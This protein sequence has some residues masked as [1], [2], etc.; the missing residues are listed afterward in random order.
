VRT[1]RTHPRIGWVRGDQAMTVEQQREMVGLRERIN[2]LETEKLAA[3]S[4]LVEDLA[5]IAQGDE[6]VTIPLLISDKYDRNIERAL[7]AFTST[8]DD[9]FAEIG[10]IMLDEASEEDVEERLES[11]LLYGTTRSEKVA[12]ALE[13]FGTAASE[14]YYDD[15]DMVCVQLRSLGLIDNGTKKRPIHD[16]GKY[17]VLTDRGRRHLITLRAV[18]KGV[19]PGERFLK[20]DDDNDDNDNNDRD[21]DDQNG[22]ADQPDGE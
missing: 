9:I 14:I 13:A 4:A 8:W 16:T 10:P 17:L 18:K 21:R 7:L 11:H 6:T 12:E 3:E 22:D 5:G 1:I 19:D 2:Q 20:E 15:W